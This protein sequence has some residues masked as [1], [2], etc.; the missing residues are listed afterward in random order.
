[1]RQDLE[2]KKETC[3]FQEYAMQKSKCPLSSNHQLLITDFDMGM[4]TKGNKMPLRI[5]SEAS[6][7]I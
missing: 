5:P 4:H 3:P 1:M 6:N 7:F 2:K